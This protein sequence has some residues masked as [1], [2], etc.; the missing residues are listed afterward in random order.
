MKNR[1]EINYLFFFSVGLFILSCQG[2]EESP[3]ESTD[4]ASV[5]DWE[6]LI[7]DGQSPDFV[8]SIGC[9]EDFHAL[10]SEPLDSSIPGARSIKTIIDRVDG[11]KLYFQNS[12]TY[13]IHWNFAREHLSG[14]GKPIVPALAQFNTTEYYSP[15]RRFILGAVTY[16]EGAGVW[17]YEIAPYDTASSDMIASA[18]Q[19]ISN[20]SFFGEELYFHP[21]SQAIE[22]ESENLPSS[23][24]IIPT[25]K[26]FEGIDYQPLN[27]GTSIGK[28][29]FITAE[30]LE[31]EYVGFRDIVVLDR[32]PNDISVVMG[33]IT[34]E[35][36]TPLSHINVLS[37]NR[38]TPN[39]GLKDA[40]SHEAMRALEGKWVKLEVGPFEYSITEVSN[41][42]ADTWWEENKPDQVLVPTLDLD[43]TDLRNIEDILD[44]E[45]KGL[46]ESLKEA[47]PAFGGKASHFAAF[48]HMD[49]D[50]IRF[51]KAFAV[52]VHYYWQFME[53]NGFHD[54]LN[55]MMDDPE[56]NNNP[57]I[58]DT[59]LKELRDAIKAA[60]ID[61]DFEA[62]LTKKLN[63]DYP[64][65]RMRFRSSTNCED[66]DG[67]TG[68]GLYTSRSGDPND[69]DYPILDAIR[70]VWASVW[71]FRAF[72]ERSYR[73][74]DH[75]SVGMALLV[76]NSFPW[77]E[78]NG[79]AI[80]ANPFD[81]SGM[82]PGFYV[83]VQVGDVSVVQP[84]SGI[85]SDQFVY[86]FDMPGQPIVFIAH[87]SLVLK[88]DTVI[89]N[90]QTYAL[91]VALK[92]IHGF[93]QHLYGP[94]PNE[95][96]A[97]DVE[98]KFDQPEPQGD[99]EEEPV[100]FVKQ[101]RPYPGWGRE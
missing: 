84:S 47:I 68:A 60:P 41:E 32:V 51:P 23:V 87:S 97:M 22:T 6:C 37:Q 91:G 40:F 34:E 43:T 62:L 64:G 74:I 66:L 69:P 13:Q 31:T 7:S 50:K 12:T 92:E 65:I 36:Q 14:N 71:Y 78:A 86:H 63:S 39:M 94:N 2:S 85:T 88:G 29:R 59:R 18:C 44:I 73:S 90:A 72:E 100:L 35:F 45:N 54:Q 99:S 26:L 28:L 42:E 38:G 67:F 81:T 17:A 9:E 83:N 75:H 8:T 19:A 21:T 15:S 79:V 25:E 101:A 58:R 57:N 96:Y 98:F 30:Q 56:F 4:D 24:R 76:H 95:W 46:G 27:Y 33:I 89:T 93:F 49:N 3:D 1:N 20:A 61:P 55:E 80:T 48:P 70:T 82:E 5:K 10:A 16:Y 53:T 77:E 52:P 11:E